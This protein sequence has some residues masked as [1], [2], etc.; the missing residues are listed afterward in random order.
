MA[1]LH[2]LARADHIFT[3]C[4][5]VERIKLRD[6]TTNTLSHVVSELVMR[7][8]EWPGGA[9]E[10][11]RDTA[12]YTCASEA[13]REGPGVNSSTL[14]RFEAFSSLNF[15]SFVLFIVEFIFH[16]ET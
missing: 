11:H 15:R 2:T 10:P 9:L 8:G 6:Y 3:K 5:V 12:T 1:S 4:Q 7:V 16:R 14:F 13:N